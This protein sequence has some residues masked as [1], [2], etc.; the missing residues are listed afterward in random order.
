MK[1]MT[2][3]ELRELIKDIPDYATI[4]EVRFDSDFNILEVE[5]FGN[6][7]SK[8]DCLKWWTKEDVQISQKNDFPDYILD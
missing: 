4:G 7:E 6:V 5:P 1:H 2:M 3:G 8:E